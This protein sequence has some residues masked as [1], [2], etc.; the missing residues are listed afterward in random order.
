[1]NPTLALFF[2]FLKVGLFSFGSATSE[3]VMEQVVERKKWL[4]P[5][6][7]RNSLSLAALVPGPFNVNMVAMTGNA[8]RGYPGVL[9]SVAG[10]VLPGLALAALLAVSL[11]SEPVGRFLR[12]NPGVIAGMLVAVAGLLFNVI[13]NLGR[14]TLANP[15]HWIWVIGLAGL[16]YFVRLPFA[17]VILAAGCASALYLRRAP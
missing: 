17:A 2:T 6:E 15:L 10:F 16:L 13:I 4:T 12:E 7:F 14:R 9:V 11:E 1:M 5:D 8:I 3:V